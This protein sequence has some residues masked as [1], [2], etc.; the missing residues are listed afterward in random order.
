[1]VN[2]LG[3]LTSR[4]EDLVSEAAGLAFFLGSLLDSGS[5]AFSSSPP[6][7]FLQ[8]SSMTGAEGADRERA[9]IILLCLS[10]S[11]C[12]SVCLSLSMYVCMYVC[13]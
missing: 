8:S 11:L 3:T 5:W 2:T 4:L 6:L 13:M 12:L 10:V 7:L 9:S 1:M